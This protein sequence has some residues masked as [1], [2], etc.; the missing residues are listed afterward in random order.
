MK[1]NIDNTPLFS[2]FDEA[3][4][5]TPVDPIIKWPGGKEKEL[6]YILPNLPQKIERYI[7]PF[8]GGGSVFAAIPAKRFL[9][10]DKSEDL[11]SLYCAIKS[12]DYD[13]FSYAEDID[14]IWK[15]VN[16]DFSVLPKIYQ[17]YLKLREQDVSSEEFKFALL[18][19]CK[20]IESDLASLVG[21]YF[22]LSPDVLKKEV[23]K[24]LFRKTLRMRELEKERHPLSTE[25]LWDNLVTVL[26]SA[27]YMY[28]RHLY[29]ISVPEIE[30][31]KSLRQALFLFI[32]NYAYSGM[33]RYN[34]KGEFNVPYGGIGYNKK[35]LKGK[36]DFY[37]SL[38]LE[39]RLKVTQMYCGDFA[40][41][42]DKVTPVE[43]DFIFL[44]PPYDTEFSTYDQNAFARKDQERLANY[45]ISKCKAKWMMIIKKTDFIYNLYKK[46][47]IY[48]KTFDKSYTVSFMNRNE[49]DVIHLLI[50]NYPI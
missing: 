42:F 14:K 37:R 6:R 41:F 20:Q 3:N 31:Y 43:D 1:N 30:T 11:M 2:I 36:L 35:T 40:D 4:E 25:D 16:K 18:P 28:F 34:A 8:V 44:D 21:K 15:S 50:T 10:N 17:L 27:I 38:S 29:N 22:A 12:K 9:I 19:L 46:E 33:F 23:E 47:G 45:L 39:A 5:L 26:K 13:F 7:E 24:N 32:R 48:I 49:K